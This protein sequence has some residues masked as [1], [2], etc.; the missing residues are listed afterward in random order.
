MER[1]LALRADQAQRGEYMAQMRGRFSELAARHDNG[2]APVAVSSFNLFQTPREVAERMAALVAN[3]LRDVDAPRILEPSAG[4]GRIYSAIAAAVPAARVVCVDASND[5]A[6]Q[7]HRLA[8]DRDGDR[9]Y[10]RDFLTCDQ[11]EIGGTLF[12]AVAMNPP[13]KQGADIRH[14]LHARGLV[15]PGGLL[16]SLCYDGARQNATLRPMAAT[17]EQLPRNSFRE[18]GTSADVVMLTM[19]A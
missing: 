15:R 18:A 16:V 17:W 14:I 12:D 7:L 11:W 19:T 4:L 3:H 13:F 5:C 1:L 9:I 2:S 10:T 8:V 6:Q